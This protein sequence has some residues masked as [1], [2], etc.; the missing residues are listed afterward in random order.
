MAVA[1]NLMVL[2]VKDKQFCVFCPIV[3]SSGMYV[4]HRTKF[5]GVV[6]GNPALI[7]IIT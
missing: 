6:P 5:Y 2:H 4:A 7:K 1:G 3:H